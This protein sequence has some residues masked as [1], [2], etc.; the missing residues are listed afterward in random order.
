[1]PKDTLDLDS[2]ELLN[3]KVTVKKKKTQKKRKKKNY[4]PAPLICEANP[5]SMKGFG[6]RGEYQLEGTV[7]CIYEELV[8]KTNK[9]IWSSR[10]NTVR[11]FGGMSVEIN[12]LIL[13]SDLGGY[14][15][16]D[17]LIWAKRNA[18]VVDTSGTYNFSSNYLSYDIKN[19]LLNLKN[20]AHLQKIFRD[21]IYENRKSGI[22]KIKKDTLD[23]MA[24]NILYNDSLRWA[25]AKNNVQILRGKLRVTCG[26]AYYSED[27]EIIDFLDFPRA[28]FKHNLM[29]GDTM[30]LKLKGEEF[31]S[32]S[33]KS[34]A[35][36][37]FYENEDSTT[38]SEEYH[39]KGDSIFMEMENEQLK[40]I[41]TFKSGYATHILKKYPNQ[42]NQMKGRYIKL[43]FKEDKIDSASLYNRA[44][45]TYFIYDNEKFKGKN[46]AQGDTIIITFK[47]GKVNNIYIKGSALGTFFGEEESVASSDS[48]KV[49]EE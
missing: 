14:K 40:F 16:K 11:F 17:G 29:Q 19:R 36:G 28:T 10:K 8:F 1:M 2:S 7:T 26:R 34:Q 22:M 4:N 21:T 24:K 39:V 33:F 18:K 45:S 15:K 31:E 41:E 48:L 47:E 25:E 12:G 35:K 6:N 5:G 23:I 42:I 9:A 3:S 44:K 13:T 49:E 32:M 37:D 20:N 38:A 27:S 30:R 43:N 46:E